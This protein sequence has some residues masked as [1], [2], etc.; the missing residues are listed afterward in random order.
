MES[1]E[2]E[3]SMRRRTRKLFA[4]QECL[5]GLEAKN[6]SFVLHALETGALTAHVLFFKTRTPKH[7]TMHSQH[8]HL[9]SDTTF[10]EKNSLSKS[11]VCSHNCFPRA[12][13][14]AKGFGDITSQS[15]KYNPPFL[16]NLICK[17]NEEEFSNWCR[18]SDWWK[19]SGTVGKSLP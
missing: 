15:D 19:K 5:I 4:P 11:S 9:L 18:W 10:L 3:I 12:S 1:K 13:S 7:L 16:A 2:V 17:R 14:S 6:Y 8:F